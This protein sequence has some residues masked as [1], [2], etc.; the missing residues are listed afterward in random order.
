MIIWTVNSEPAIVEHMKNKRKYKKMDN[1]F[2]EYAGIIID[3]GVYNL[4]SGVMIFKA[5]GQVYDDGTYREFLSLA[6]APKSE[7]ASPKHMFSTPS[8]AAVKEG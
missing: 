8:G 5:V 3:Q 4:P 1:I 2:N 7:P 6:A